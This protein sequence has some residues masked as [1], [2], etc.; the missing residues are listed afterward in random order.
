MGD[1]TTGLTNR[2]CMNARSLLRN[3]WC[4]RRRRRHRHRGLAKSFSPKQDPP[5]HCSVTHQNQPGLEEICLGGGGAMLRSAPIAY[6]QSGYTVVISDPDGGYTSYTLL[7]FMLKSSQIELHVGLLVTVWAAMVFQ[8]FTSGSW[9]TMRH[10]VSMTLL[11]RCCVRIENMIPLVC[12]WS[13]VSCH[14]WTVWEQR[15][16]E[17]KLRFLYHLGE[18]PE[19]RSTH[20]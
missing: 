16:R 1:G 11:W 19:P 8:V 10:K 13:M 15:Q 7:V 3:W 6:Q 18:R 14:A 2:S 17:V 20:K 5:L 9:F 4:Y 12:M